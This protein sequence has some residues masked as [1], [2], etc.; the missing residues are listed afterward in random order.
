MGYAWMSYSSAAKHIPDAKRLGVSTVARSSGGFMGNYKRAGSS[1]KMNKRPLGRNTVG[2]KTWGQKR[3]AFI[4][5]HLAQYKKNKTERRWYA[6]V[7]WAYM[8][9]A[10]PSGKKKSNKSKKTKRTKK[11]KRPSSRRR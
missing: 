4:K 6:L 2:G 8:P 7:M 9:G 11:K 5:R 10:K 1:S 3:E